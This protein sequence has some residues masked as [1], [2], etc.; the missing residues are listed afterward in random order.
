MI[1]PLLILLP[2]SEPTTVWWRMLGD[3]LM[4]VALSC[5]LMPTTSQ[6]KPTCGNVGLTT[7]PAS[8]QP[9]YPGR[10]TGPS[11][12]TKLGEFSVNM[13]FS[14][15]VFTD[16]TVERLETRDGY[17]GFNDLN[18]ASLNGNEF[19]ADYGMTC[20]H[21]ANQ[22][23]EN[24]KFTVTRTV[25]GQG[26]LCKTSHSLVNSPLPRTMVSRFSQECTGFDV[27]MRVEIFQT[28]GQLKTMAPYALTALNF[29]G[30]NLMMYQATESPLIL[31]IIPAS[32]DFQITPSPQCTFTVKNTS[33][34]LASLQNSQIQPSDTVSLL[35]P[36]TFSLQLQSCNSVNQRPVNLTWRFNQPSQNNERMLNSAPAGGKGVDVVLRAQAGQKK[37]LGSSTPHADLTIKHLETY[38]VLNA[39]ENARLQFTA[40]YVANGDPPSAGAFASTAIVT[41]GYE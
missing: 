10:N 21:C 6:A 17:T 31:A 38:R 15:C 33:V 34:G 37:V 25:T 5:L 22:P 29:I 16:T 36:K 41:L 28:N 12:T 40:A 13:N 30:A 14:H 23:A 9:L 4:L 27:L 32:R 2:R 39:E 18:R 20:Q 19:Q 35:N 8:T 26:G 11:T 3:A 7:H 1:A 24:I